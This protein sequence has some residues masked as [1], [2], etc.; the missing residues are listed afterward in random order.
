MQLE[1]RKLG[2][3]EVVRDPQRPISDDSERAISGKGMTSSRANRESLDWR[4]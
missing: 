1:G 4:L 3:A 2:V